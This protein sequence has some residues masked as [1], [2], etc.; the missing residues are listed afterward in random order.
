MK[1]RQNIWCDRNIK[2]KQ[3]EPKDAILLRESG[4]KKPKKLKIRQLG[5]YKIDNILTS[6]YLNGARLKPY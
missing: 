1:R 4:L 5:P 6:Y 3:L 2:N